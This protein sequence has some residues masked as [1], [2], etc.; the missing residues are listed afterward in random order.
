MIKKSTLECKALEL[1]YKESSRIFFRYVKQAQFLLGLSLCLFLL[2]LSA[3]PNEPEITQVELQ[4]WSKTISQYLKDPL[5]QERDAYDVTHAAMIPLHAAFLLGNTSWQQ[6]FSGHFTRFLQGEGLTSKNGAVR[7][8]YTYL[9][10]RFITLAVRT[11]NKDM[12]PK[13]L[14]EATERELFSSWQR[15]ARTK[16]GSFAS[17]RER[18]MWRLSEAPSKRSWIK[19]ILDTELFIFA[20]GADLL[21]VGYMLG[22][23]Q[24]PVLREIMDTATYVFENAPVLLADGG[25]LFQPGV[26]KDHP[27]HRYANHAE[28]TNDMK[29]K[30]RENITWD[31]GHTMRFPLFLLSL[32]QASTDISKQRLFHDLRKGLATQFHGHVLKPSNTQQPHWQLNNYMD[33]WN[34]LYR[35]NYKT[36]GQGKGISAYGLSKSLLFGWWAF[37][38]TD[39]EEE[40]FKD[41]VSL[42][43]FSPETRAIYGTQTSSRTKHP[44]VTIPSKYSNGL[45]ELTMRLAHKLSRS[46]SLSL[47]IED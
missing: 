35:W 45:A 21:N 20:T 1:E 39:K 42:F 44:L 29:P 3:A 33:G 24:E 2:P 31:S 13:G 30:T 5:W 36:L 47:K 18:I 38:G 23:K 27:D 8:H 26:W 43:P 22:R 12:I 7:A 40:V 37:L 6:E 19:G 14:Y 46:G 10:A 15:T 28:P 25:W 11:G 16:E 17:V 9:C 34:G 32:E 4:L 41:M